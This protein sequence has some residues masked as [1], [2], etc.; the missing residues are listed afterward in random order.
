MTIK[1]AASGGMEWASID[2]LPALVLNKAAVNLAVA[3]QLVLAMVPAL[4]L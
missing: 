3:M 1:V 4:P 2:C